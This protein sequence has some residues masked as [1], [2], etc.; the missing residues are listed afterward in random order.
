MADI[1]W[2]PNYCR[3]MQ[4]DLFQ[5][6][7]SLTRSE[8]RHFTLQASTHR[9]D[10][11]HLILFRAIE[12][13]KVYD[14]KPLRE[15]LREKGYSE[16]FSVAKS[17]LHRLIM[18]VLRSYHS[19]MSQNIKV[20]EL[21]RDVEIL[22]SKGLLDQAEKALNKAAVIAETNH[23]HNHMMQ[24]NHWRRDLLYASH[25]IDSSAEE[26][27][28]TYEEL[29]REAER[30]INEMEL[31]NSSR[32]AF[33]LLAM[34]PPLHDRQAADELERKMPP[35]IVSG[36]IPPGAS[37][38]TVANLLY[39]RINYLATI[40]ELREHYRCCQEFLSF[41]RNSPWLDPRSTN[42]LT[43]GLNAL[44][45]NLLLRSRYPEAN[46]VLEEFRV[47]AFSDA[48]RTDPSMQGQVILRYME[49]RLEIDAGL[50][51]TAAAVQRIPEFV[52]EMKRLSS[53]LTE[54]QF[55]ALRYH[56]GI[57]YFSAGEFRKALTWMEPLLSFG[58][59]DR[60]SH[61]EWSY[62]LI[63]I[64][65][66]LIHYELGDEDLLEYLLKSYYRFLANCKQPFRI[67]QVFLRFLRRV[68]RLR[69]QRDLPKVLEELAEELRE[70]HRN[71]FEV[72][73]SVPFVLA[74]AESKI[75]KKNLADILKRNAER[76]ADADI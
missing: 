52:A 29:Y 39:T 69:D 12:K 49:Q 48:F 6:V 20:A 55:L 54:P 13:Q 43:L 47:A 28:R 24:V 26:L 63:R 40:Y 2:F 27:D 73:M 33:D 64:A 66:L 19:E 31:T 59:G 14:E 45:E 60:S 1:L 35:G 46:N 17:Y 16:H 42:H 44:L 62:S 36:E 22:K 75:E 18:K 70:L 4:D 50:G 10:A 76:A 15:L 65:Q 30:I 25:T 23:L 72:R 38:I 58:S 74:W 56:I 8:K 11:Q 3:H 51:D 71:P 67:E 41:V 21:L 32:R 61:W 37:Y 9:K 68:L 57:T 7:K 5:L 53:T 34:T